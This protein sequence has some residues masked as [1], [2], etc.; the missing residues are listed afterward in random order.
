MYYQKLWR[1]EKQYALDQHAIVAIMDVNGNIVYA[2]EKFSVLT[3]YD[4]SELIGKNHRFLDSGQN[5]RNF[6]QLMYKVLAEGSVWHGEICNR[7]RNGEIYWLD[8]TIVPFDSHQKKTN[9]DNSN[10]SSEQDVFHQQSAGSYISISTDITKLK[11]IEKALQLSE[12]RYDFAMSVVND[13][14]WDWRLDN[15]SIYFDSRYYTMLGYEDGEF[16]GDFEEFKKRVHA[17]DFAKVIRQIKQY[18]SGEQKSFDSEFRFLRK[19]GRYLWVRSRGRIIER[20]K[21][22][23]PLR[24]LGT[25]ADIN[26]RKL[27]EQ[28]LVQ[29]ER[30]FRNLIETTSAVVWEY[31]VDSESFL[32]VSPQVEKLSGYPVEMWTGLKF[33]ISLIHPD[34]LDHVLAISRKAVLSGESHSYEYRVYIADGSIK[35]FR[36]DINVVLQN[37]QS[38]LMR[39]F[40]VDITDLKQTEEALR[41]SQKM[42]AIGQLTGGI[43]H[44]FNNILGIILGNLDLLERQ[45]ELNE[46]AVKRVSGIRHSA[47]RAVDLTRQ[48]LGFSRRDSLSARA[49]DVNTVIKTMQDLIK[50]SITPEVEVR[51]K[52]SEPLWRVMIDAGELEDALLNL[53]INARDAIK[54]NGSL[55]IETGNYV[56]GHSSDSSTPGMQAG[57]Y[58]EIQ[59][60]DSGEGISEENIEHIYEPF[61]TTKAQGKGTGLGLAMVFGFV[62]RSSGYIR[63]DSEQGTGT[64]F[65]IYLPRFVSEDITLPVDSKIEVALPDGKEVIL[66]VDDEESLLAITS[67]N[68]QALGYQVW[69]ASSAE[70]ALQIMSANR[71]DL[72]FSD[73]VMPEM[74]G[75]ELA[76]QVVVLYPDTKVLLT[77]GYTEKAHVT[78]KES[79]FNV[80]LLSKPYTQVVLAKAIRQKLDKH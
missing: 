37:N 26:H 55:S 69:T 54:G 64:T 76:E 72:L 57:E 34:D 6:F 30:H 9:N 1:D 35:W 28:A 31:D 33:W 44:D 46:K 60:S 27:T 40:T 65:R 51:L 78:D 71:I 13:G 74:N 18:L 24:F 22:G 20:D 75:Y 50:R 36:S 17:D 41:R 58:I 42:D 8:T 52:L 23:E 3:G 68:L 10:E 59:V 11:R 21:N 29:S 25:H 14:I 38:S 32:Y 45:G 67:E 79:R 15:N 5:D 77:S 66:V 53:V 4:S 2:N 12:Q 49:T 73:V 39:G 48:L 63:V 16:P 56:L 80:D 47:Q 62:Q 7:S 43:A 19:D 61:F 70:R